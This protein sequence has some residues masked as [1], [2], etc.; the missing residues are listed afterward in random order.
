VPEPVRVVRAPDLPRIGA[1]TRAVLAELTRPRPSGQW[2]PEYLAPIV[3]ARAI[4]ADDDHGRAHGIVVQA[5]GLRWDELY[6]LTDLVA[7]AL[8]VDQHGSVGSWHPDCSACT[9][10]TA[11][12]GSPHSSGTRQWAEPSV[13]QTTLTTPSRGATADDLTSRSDHRTLCRED[14]RTR[15]VALAGAHPS[16]DAAPA[17]REAAPL[18]PRTRDGRDPRPSPAAR[19]VPA[20]QRRAPSR[21]RPVLETAVYSRQ[22]ARR[23]VVLRGR[24]ARM[25]WLSEAAPD[26]PHDRHR[27]R[28]TGHP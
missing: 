26:A 24:P 12:V 15:L 1:A 23:W 9:T 18:T 6:P 5:D 17:R 16:A 3:A 28:C 7:S 4:A 2:G 20:G 21:R 11:T 22:L 13:T 14:A 8:D 19:H 25:P 27:R 10:I